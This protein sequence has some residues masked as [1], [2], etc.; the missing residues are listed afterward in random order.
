MHVD[1]LQ[2][3]RTPKHAQSVSAVAVHRGSRTIST[4]LHVEG[5]G[6]AIAADEVAS[7]AAA[8]AA[9]VVAV[10]A[11][12]GRRAPCLYATRY[13]SMVTATANAAAAVCS[14]A[15]LWLLAATGTAGAAPVGAPC[16]Q[17]IA[18][19]TTRHLLHAR[20]GQCFRRVD[21]HSPASP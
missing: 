10:R 3:L 5:G 18:P 1:G 16:T 9:V 4:A 12:H 19:C 13:T 21:V 8:A 17:A 11:C 2:C 7:K 15:C 20:F 14:I 6:A